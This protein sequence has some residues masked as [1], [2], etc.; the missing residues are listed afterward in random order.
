VALRLTA[1]AGTLACGRS[2]VREVSYDPAVILVAGAS[3]ELGGRVVRELRGRGVSVRALLRAG[4]DAS[5]LEAADVDVVRGDVRDRSSLDAACAGVETAVSGVTAISRLL[6][7]ERTSFEAVDH[8]GNVNLIEAAEQARVSRFVFI[9]YAGVDRGGAHPLARAKRAV[10]R[11]LG[12]SPMRTVIVRPDMFHEVWLTPITQLDW[13]KGVLSIL[14]RGDTPARYV[15][16]EDVAALTAAVAVEPDP[17]ELVE[18]GGSEPLTRNQVADVIEEAAGK[19]MKRR[20]MPRPVLRVAAPALA[21]FRPA[22]ATIFGLGLTADSY[23]PT[24]TEA[25][26]QAR[27]ITPRSA[28]EFLQ[29]QVRTPSTAQ[30]G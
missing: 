22:T 18:F 20:H 19:P 14:G 1:V 3:G 24:W 6:A 25:P 5:P 2:W 11:R 15:S 27:G 10:E 7:G 30:T 29:H 26:L 4:R 16:V 8:Q 28:R 21:R 13:E 12:Q 23:P 9:S 17:P